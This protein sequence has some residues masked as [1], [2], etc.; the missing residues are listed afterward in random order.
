MTDPGERDSFAIDVA[1]AYTPSER[2]SPARIVIEGS[3]IAAIGPPDQVGGAP[4]MPR[5]EAGDLIATPGFIDPHIHGSSGADVMEATWD[6]LNTVSGA[7]ASH[8]T[9]SFLP[10]TVSASTEV[11]GESIRR[12]GGLQ[13]GGFVGANPIGIHLEGPFISP[14]RRGAHPREHIRDAD[15]ALL[16]EWIDMSDGAV[17]LLT[18][19]PE[20]EGIDAVIKVAQARGVTVAMGHSDATMETALEAADLGVCYAVHT[21]NAMRG[22]HHRDPGI[23]GAVLADDRVRAEIIVDGVHVDPAL[24]RV[25]ARSK[26]PEQV[27]LVTDGTSATGMPDGGYALG[28]ATVAV[29]EG[30]CRDSEGRLAGS[31]LTQDI[32]LRNYVEWT[33]ADLAAGLEALTTNPAAALGIED[34][35]RLREGSEADIVLLDRALTVIRTYVGGRTVFDK[36]HKD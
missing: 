27:L 30:V 35:G 17:R 18:I 11:L 13:E 31:T 28:A 32:A 2:I 6:A 23:A 4:D 24:V 5:I 25:F 19:A 7:L 26:G 8:G 1:A 15:A 12:L 34:L 9:T 3:R 36:L 16:E 10:T 29:A 22:L 14:I 20:V 21:F 33:G